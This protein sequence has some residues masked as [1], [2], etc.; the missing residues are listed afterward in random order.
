[1]QEV[2]TNMTDPM[3]NTKIITN[4][5]NIP[6]SQ[7]VKNWSWDEAKYPKSRGLQNTLTLLLSVVNKLD[8][9]ARNKSSRFNEVKTAQTNAVKKQ[10]GSLMSK[11]M[12]DIL[13]PGVVGP[14]DF[15]YTEHVT[16][17]VMILPQTR[18]EPF[19]KTYH[20]YAENV[21][22]MSAK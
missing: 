6:F 22:P 15:V 5:Q 1:M 12:I 8:E 16:T 21:V 20:T 19:L 18:V 3:N 13:T 10:Q 9:E 17:L 11:D 14:S 2:E 7:Y 4:T